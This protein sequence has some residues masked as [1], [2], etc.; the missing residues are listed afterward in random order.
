[1]LETI[2]GTLVSWMMFSSFSRL[3][4]EFFSSNMTGDTVSKILSAETLRSYLSEK[5]M[6]LG[7]DIF[8]S[9]IFLFFLIYLSPLLTFVAVITVPIDF[10][11]SYLWTKKR[12]NLANKF[13]VLANE[14]NGTLVESISGAETVYQ[15]DASETFSKI[16]FEE[17]IGIVQN[18]VSLKKLIQ[19]F[20]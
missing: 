3:P 20:R 16:W 14:H 7:M 19:F 9:F 8:F 10:Y 11:L 1:M 12:Q 4:L 15:M 5:P 2:L 18:A 6:K 17:I 13:V